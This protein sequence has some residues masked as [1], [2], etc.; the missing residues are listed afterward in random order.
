MMSGAVT[1]T[2]EER[3]KARTAFETEHKKLC[4][5]EDD[6]RRNWEG[7][8]HPEQTPHRGC[9]TVFNETKQQWEKEAFSKE[10]ID[11][12]CERK[13]AGHSAMKRH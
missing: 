5:A 1:L 11:I 6:A 2:T 4:E 10:E 7:P 12:N 13:A 8:G 3:E 9:S